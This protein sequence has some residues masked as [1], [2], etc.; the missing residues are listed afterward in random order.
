[1]FL[2]HLPTLASPART[3]RFYDRRQTDPWALGYGY[4]DW[5]AIHILPE[6]GPRP[7]AGDTDR[8]LAAVPSC[9]SIWSR[10]I[11]GCRLRSFS[12]ALRPVVRP[13]RSEVAGGPPRVRPG[14]SEK[15][16]LSVEIW[17]KISQAEKFIVYG[18]VAVIVGWLV[19]L[20]MASVN[21]C[22]G[23][24]ALCPNVNYFS[25][26]TAG[27]TAILALVVAI[28]TL[29]VIYLKVAP[30]MNITWP[31][32]VVQILLGLCAATLIL[33]AITALLNVT[34]GLSSPPIGMYIADLLIVAGGAVM[35]W[36]AY[37]GFLASKVA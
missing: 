37:Q 5:G 30:N 20:I 9:D 29:V 28:V 34:S 33:A 2:L 22:A 35:T 1:L 27:T 36:F 21:A 12:S 16:A 15:E 4:A 32:P 26:S 10:P 11:P 6:A 14:Y 17:A 23:L 3:I 19:G 8:R 31:M 7:S 13:N 24:S 25:W 18:A